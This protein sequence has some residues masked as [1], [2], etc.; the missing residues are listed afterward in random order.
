MKLLD[1]RIRMIAERSFTFPAFPGS[2]IRGA[3]GACLRELACVTK[4]QDCT[5]C[6]ARQTCAYAIV[7]APVNASPGKGLDGLRDVPR[8]YALDVTSLAEG[9]IEK[10][11]AF[12]LGMGLIGPAISLYPFVAGAFARMGRTGLGAAGRLAR[13]DRFEGRRHGRRRVISVETAFRE[14]DLPVQEHD[15]RAVLSRTAHAGSDERH[16]VGIRLLTPFRHRRDGELADGVD[17]G[18]FARTLARRVGNLARHHGDGRG[19]DDVDF[20]AIWAAADEVPTVSDATR[21]H[22]ASR[23]SAKQGRRH[24]IGG[25]VGDLTFA[26]DADRWLPLLELGE[27]LG[28]GKGASFGLGRYRVT[29]DGSRATTT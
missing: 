15:I 7:F 23:Y 8:P 2:E 24:A 3:F 11:E 22:E 14:S 12:E 21:W 20:R 9:P 19:I 5:A 18:G 25:R 17:F 29:H 26:L 1:L 27:T 28:I 4:R 13:V 16:H 10:G 6:P